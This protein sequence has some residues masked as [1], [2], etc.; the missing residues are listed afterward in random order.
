MFG[1]IISPR[2]KQTEVKTPTSQTLQVP[3]QVRFSIPGPNFTPDAVMDRRVTEHDE[4]RTAARA[5]AA[6]AVRAGKKQLEEAN[7]MYEQTYLEN[8]MAL[9][10]GPSCCC[11]RYPWQHE[12]HPSGTVKRN[13]EREQQDENA[14]VVERGAEA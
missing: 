4:L 9:E 12:L 7:Q 10:Y 13:A 1:E 3:K 6:A 5:R 2:Q 8:L 14:E 11:N